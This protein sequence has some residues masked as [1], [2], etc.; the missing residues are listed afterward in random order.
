MKAILSERNVTFLC[1]LCDQ[2]EY[3]GNILLGHY[4]PVFVLKRVRM[5]REVGDCFTILHPFRFLGCPVQ[6]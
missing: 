3:V 6:W 5:T 4:S 2:N 1:S